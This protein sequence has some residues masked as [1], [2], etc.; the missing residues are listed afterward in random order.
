MNH[1]TFKISTL[2]A[3]LVGIAATGCSDNLT[4]QPELPSYQ[5]E[6]PVEL[7]CVPDLDERIDADELT[8]A[9][10]VPVRYRINPAGT[11]VEVDLAGARDSSGIRVWD[12]SFQN[13]GDQ[14]LTVAADEMDGKWYAGSFPDGQFVTDLDAAGRE[15]A[16]YSSGPSGLLLHGFASV[17][18]EPENGQTLFIYKD[19]VI[20]YPFPIEPGKT[21]VSTGIVENGLFRGLPYAGRDVYEGSVDAIGEIWLPDIR[22]EQAHKVTTS[23]NVQPAVGQSTSR[24]QVSFLFECFGEV[25][26]AVSQDNET[27]DNF[28]VATEV[29]RLGF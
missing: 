1:T 24:K 10:G 17:E 11:E 27:D 4:P 21:W 26:R 5:S 19:P 28:T 2:F 6:Q 7:D 22:F 16:I 3:A 20:V 18:E 14:Q 8:A 23:V 13:P 29:R 15:E 12:W 9:I 25:A